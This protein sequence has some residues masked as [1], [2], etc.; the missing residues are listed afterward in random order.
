MTNVSLGISDV[1]G[2]LR[3]SLGG[4][5]GGGGKLPTGYG[6]RTL[7]CMV[8]AGRSSEAESV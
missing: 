6:P 7:R 1:T 2:H 8:Q 5:G 4:G 3:R